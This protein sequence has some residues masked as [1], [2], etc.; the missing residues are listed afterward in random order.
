[1]KNISIKGKT[2][3]IPEVCDDFSEKSYIF[4]AEQLYRH[5]NGEIDSFELRLLV[6]LN[7]LN[8]RIKSSK[9]ILSLSDVIKYLFT[10]LLALFRKL[11][12]RITKAD[13]MKICFTARDAYCKPEIVEDYLCENLIGL[14]DEIK[15]LNEERLDLF[16]SR[17][18]IKKLQGIGSGKRFD[19]GVALLS[20]ITA[21]QYAD[22]MD[23]AIAWNETK[24][25]KLL[26]LLVALLYSRQGTDVLT[27]TE[28]VKLQK[29]LE[30]LHFSVKYGIYL[31]F[32]SIS[33]YFNSHPLYSLLYVS[34]SIDDNAEKIRLGMNEG[35]FRLSKCGYGSHSEIRQ[36]NLIEFMDMHLSEVKSSIASALSAGIEPDK[37]AEKTGYTLTQIDML[38]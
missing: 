38:S 28:N 15:F 31:W 30:K 6:V 16:F 37:L 36:K 22:A 29:R 35:I 18:P 21:G 1:M 32:I 14:S 23:V 27:I 11:F 4:F 25:P 5:I 8:L 34:N 19:I 2:V 12:G 13:Y 10:I 24:D 17:N 20:D 3:S 26:D 33:T 9:K 7:A